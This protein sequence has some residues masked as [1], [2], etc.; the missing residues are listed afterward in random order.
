MTGVQTFALPIFACLWEY[1]AAYRLYLPD[2]LTFIPLPIDADNIPYRI[3]EMPQ[4][5]N[6]FIGIQSARNDIKGTDIMLPVLKAVC[7]KHPDK[8]T[9]TQAIDVPYTEYQKM[10]EKAD[11]QLD[12]LYAYPPS[13][14]SLLAMAKGVVVCGGGEKE[15]YEDRKS[16]V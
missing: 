8:C 3:C 5:V 6:F 12:Q 2:K 16:V 15:N 10:L 4:K 1:Y 14:N 7:D 11:V 13:M 9:M